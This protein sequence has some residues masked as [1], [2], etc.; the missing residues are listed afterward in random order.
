MPRTY[1]QWP[2]G[3]LSRYATLIPTPEF[4]KVCKWPVGIYINS[5]GSWFAAHVHGGRHEGL[6]HPVKPDQVKFDTED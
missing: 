2:N 3:A 1:K 5:D 4:P 6:K